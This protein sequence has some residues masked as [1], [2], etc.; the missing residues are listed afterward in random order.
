MVIIGWVQTSKEKRRSKRCLPRLER[1]GEL[2]DVEV[3]T[4]DLK[5]LRRSRAPNALIPCDRFKLRRRVNVI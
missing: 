2:T 3:F 4:H 1:Q 5:N